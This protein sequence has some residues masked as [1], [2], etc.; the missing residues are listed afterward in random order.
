M[1]L[2][3]VY[4]VLPTEQLTSENTELINTYVDAQNMIA[5]G[6]QEGGYEID[7]NATQ[8]TTELLDNLTFGSYKIINLLGGKLQ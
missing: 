4:N 6:M 2:E 5:E 3:E 7:E 8:K 1:T